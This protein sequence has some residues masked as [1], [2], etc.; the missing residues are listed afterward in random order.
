MVSALEYRVM[1]DAAICEATTMMA[2]SSRIA[3]KVSSDSFPSPKMAQ[4][5]RPNMRSSY[6]LL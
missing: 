1:A 2:L 4:V 3:L 5:P 6:F